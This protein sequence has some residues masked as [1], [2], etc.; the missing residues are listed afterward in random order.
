MTITPEHSMESSD[1]IIKYIVIGIIA[2]FTISVWHIVLPIL[3]V[4][5]I[6]FAILDQI[7]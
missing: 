6:L 1:S 4:F 3:I 2:I 7:S 5:I